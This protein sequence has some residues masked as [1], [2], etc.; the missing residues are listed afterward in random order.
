MAIQVLSSCSIENGTVVVNGT[1]E[2]SVENEVFSDFLKS[3]YRHLDISYPKYFKMD[4]LCQLA[5]LG[6][7][8]LLKTNDIPFTDDE[9]AL[10]FFN[11][12]SSLD[13]DSKHQ[14]LI[15]DGTKVS[16]AVFVYTLPNIMMGEIAIKNKWYGENL[17]ILR[18][19]FN[20][21]EWALEADLLISSGKATYCLGGWVDVFQDNYQLHLYLVEA[22]EIKMKLTS[23]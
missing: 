8:Y 13:T 10:C 4:K 20:F 3:A 5:F 14:Q 1:P 2:Y 15:N 7:E 18:P 16:P 21:E 23:I 9:V 22:A 6:T 17:L 19:D 12:R 11:G